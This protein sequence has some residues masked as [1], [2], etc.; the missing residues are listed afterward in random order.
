MT[1]LQKSA[2]FFGAFLVGEDIMRKVFSVALIYSPKEG[3][4]SVKEIFSEMNA[5]DIVSKS[6]HLATP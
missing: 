5:V 2:V 4:T 6:R 1:V 3:G